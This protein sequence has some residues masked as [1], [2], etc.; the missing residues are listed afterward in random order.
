MV[1]K[2]FNKYLAEA[3]GVMVLIVIGCGSVVL[4][5]SQVGHSGIA[6][7]FGFA[8]MAL[9]Y[10]LSPISGGHLNPAISFGMVIAKRMTAKEAFKY[11]VAQCIGALI[12]CGVL[13]LIASGKAGYDLA[14]GGL[15]QNGYG[16]RSPGR[17]SMESAF[18]GEFV[19]TMI[20]VFVVLSV[21][22]EGASAGFAAMAY[23]AIILAIHLIGIS[24]TGTS[25]NPARSFGPA[26]ITGGKSLTQLWLFIVAPML[27][28][29]AAAF[30]YNKMNCDGK[31]DAKKK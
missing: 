10:A 2:D 31:K 7:A 21:T 9:H 1:S 27:G 15:A 11:T 28:G 6:L 19:L 30:L 14:H 24:L 25:V 18:V 16:P 22:A 8:V 23:G 4:P 13:Y 29:V 26:V 3:F 20:L 5:G 17:F 12:G